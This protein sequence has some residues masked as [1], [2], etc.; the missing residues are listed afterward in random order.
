M[1]LDTDTQELI[2]LLER[3]NA[4]AIAELEEML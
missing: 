2:E 1:E 3:I 4:T